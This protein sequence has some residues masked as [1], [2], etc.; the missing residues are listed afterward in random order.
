MRKLWTDSLLLT[1]FIFF[2]TWVIYNVSALGIF[3][4]FD[5]IGDALGDMQFTDVVFSRL[6]VT[7]K[8]DTNVV[9]VN[10]GNLTRR[11]I[12]QEINIVSQFKPKEIGIDVRFLSP[13]PDTLGDLMLSEAIK[14]AG[15]VVLGDKLEKYDSVTGNFDS[16]GYSIP[17]FSKNA[18]DNA[19][20]NMITDNKASEQSQFKMTR[21]FTPQVFLKGD[22]NNDQL[23]F[24]VRLAQIYSPEKVKR[25]LKRNNQV[26]VINYRGDIRKSGY[27]GQI[28]PQ[29]TALD[30]PELFSGNFEPSVFKNKIVL[31]GFMGSNF[32]SQ[33]WED[34]FYTPMNAQYAGKA[35]PDMYG[36]VIHANII[37]MI[38][39]QEYINI[40]P[41]W[42]ENAIG[43]VIVFFNNMFFLVIYRRLSRW[44]DGL[45]ILIQLFELMGLLYLIIM[46]FHWFS[47]KLNLTLAFVGIGLAQNSLELFF[48]VFMNLFSREGRAEIFSNP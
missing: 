10:I 31:L 38:L 39:N 46:F 4:L 5:P 34:K 22:P 1:L 16:L 36:V 20:V 32:Q 25:F 14:N 45:T 3:N 8:A 13:K 44:Y 30:I 33:S 21:I 28:G 41:P 2:L 6:R 26:E 37:S 29:F 17:M 7:P 19:F 23:A 40:L 42:L 15:N 11:E 47:L 9:L 27:D 43:I 12:A 18:M 35:N 24:T 48:S